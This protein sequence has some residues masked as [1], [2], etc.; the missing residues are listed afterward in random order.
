M[1]LQKDSQLDVPSPLLEAIRAFPLAREVEHCGRK[2]KTS[3]LDLYAVCPHC[4]SR[5]KL[6]AFSGGYG[7]EDVFDAVFEWMNQPGASELVASRQK[8]IASDKDT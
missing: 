8:D 5:V 6:R 3:A 7:I 2:I 4:A 1:K